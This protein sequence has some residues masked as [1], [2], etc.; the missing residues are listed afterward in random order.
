MI[1][2]H[3]PVL[4]AEVIDLLAVGP[5]GHWLDGTIGGGGH[6][7]AILEGSAPDGRLLGLDRD[8]AALA[9]VRE[10]LARFGDRLELVEGNIAD[11]A[12]LAA[13]AQW[14]PC[15]GILFDLGISSDQL[16]DPA[17]GLS[18]Q[19][20]GPLD[21]RLGPDADATAADLVN[22]LDEDALANLIWRYGEEP[23][24]RRIARAIAAA[25]PLATT[26]A[27]AD[28]V[29]RVVR[30]ARGRRPIHPATRTFQALRIAVNDELGAVERAV[31]QAVA[32]LAP[33]GRLA[34]ITFHS[35]EDRI[36]KTAFK[37]AST[38]CTCPPELPLC[39]CGGRPTVRLITR[40]PVTPSED[41][42]RSNP[43]ARSAKLRVAE[44]LLE[45]AA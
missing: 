28:V 14:P 5:G 3:A 9:R 22:D 20:D 32:A 19:T 37:A 13:G 34:V 30:P 38:G 15:R 44:R 17:R 39:V 43:R 24:S 31:P 40:K 18:F 11:L 41:E 45:P 29:A 23:S 8:P 42:C 10:R 35:L 1:T 36:V 4:L 26:R 12:R 27:L 6:A 33:G 21:M 16:D 25:R 7:A 2:R